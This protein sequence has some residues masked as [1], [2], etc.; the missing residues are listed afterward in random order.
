ML[1]GFLRSIGSEFVGMQM[2]RS[3]IHL[4]EVRAYGQIY[5][6][7]EENVGLIIGLINLILANFD[8]WNRYLLFIAFVK[9]DFFIFILSYYLFIFFP[10]N[11][12]FKKSNSFSVVFYY[13]YSAVNFF[14][15]GFYFFAVIHKT[16]FLSNF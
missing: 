1:D 7:K 2:Y 14:Y 11:I 5:F 3:Y 4:K 6:S 9:L 16:Y 10:Y 13:N 12:C 15:V 8:K